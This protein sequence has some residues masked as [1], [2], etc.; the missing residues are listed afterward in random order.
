LDVGRLIVDFLLF[1]PSFGKNFL[2]VGL[3]KVAAVV[4]VVEGVAVPSKAYDGGVAAATS[5]LAVGL[6]RCCVLFTLIAVVAVPS[7]TY[8]G[9]VAA[10]T[11][12]LAVGLGRCGNDGI[13]HLH[14]VAKPWSNGLVKRY[15]T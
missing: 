9:G 1:D 8:D 14:S 6:G 4:A 15:V 13:L 11:S 7:K 12:T 2:V 10:A 5:T 3:W